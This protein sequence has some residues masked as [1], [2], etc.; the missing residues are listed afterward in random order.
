MDYF[1]KGHRWESINLSGFRVH[2]F[3]ENNKSR[4]SG[5]SRM[6]QNSFWV[7]DYTLSDGMECRIG[8]PR[9]E[10]IRRPKNTAHLYAPMT[11][12]WERVNSRKKVFHETWTTFQGG[13][14]TF[15]EKL[16]DNKFRYAVFHDPHEMLRPLFEEGA[17]I[18][19]KA[20]DAGFWRAE[21]VLCKIID[22]ICN[23]SKKNR[24]N[25]YILEDIPSEKEKHG[26]AEDV[27]EYLKNNVNR[28][29]SLH[30]ISKALAM[31]VSKLTHSYSRIRGEA[32]IKTHSRLRLMQIKNML[33]SGEPL[34]NIASQMGFC[35]IYHLSKFFKNMEGI[36]PRAFTSLNRKKL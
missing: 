13:E 3:V 8:S 7:I 25:Y 29:L 30:E 36:S 28:Q 11:K 34:K 12:Y 27:E 1:I 22:V 17:E 10:F 6:I 24:D 4:Y 33:L 9:K 20:G 19:Y 35:D 31:S 15:L 32:P 26:L 16:T 14:N 18:G 23:N 21:A 2:S 5:Q